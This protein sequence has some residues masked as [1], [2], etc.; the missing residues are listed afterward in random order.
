M[1]RL[2]YAEQRTR[3][4]Q[5]SYTKRAG[6][7]RFPR[8]HAYVEDQNGGVQIN[9][10]V[11]Q[12]EASYG[13]TSAHSGEYDGSLVEREMSRIRQFIGSM[14][15]TDTISKPQEPVEKKSFWSSLFGS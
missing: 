7:E 1:R 2:G 14:K 8:Y 13:G 3:Q 11:D 15:Q 5:I 10:H 12:K 4:G 6:T 9:L